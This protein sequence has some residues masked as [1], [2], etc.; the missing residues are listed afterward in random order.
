MSRALRFVVAA[1]LIAVAAAGCSERRAMPQKPLT[2]EKAKAAVLAE[3]KR[4]VS[5]VPPGY[6]ERHD[7]L[8]SAHLLSCA[9]G[10]YTWPDQGGVVL[11]GNPDIEAL[12]D[13]VADGYR[14]LSGFTVTMGKTADGSRRLRVLGNDG[15]DY[16]VS[17]RE[18]NALLRIASFS[19]CFELGP[20]QWS[21]DSY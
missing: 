21:G 8:A 12:L 20:D 7:Q 15:A 19:A 18:S 10:R 2:V 3:E 4:L 11:K 16:L 6:V 17:P 1:V 9:G 13:G 5:F 14:K